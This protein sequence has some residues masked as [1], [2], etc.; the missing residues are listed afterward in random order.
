MTSPFNLANITGLRS[1]FLFHYKKFGTKSRV[2]DLV[3]R[4]YEIEAMP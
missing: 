1:K 2:E 3:M 4:D